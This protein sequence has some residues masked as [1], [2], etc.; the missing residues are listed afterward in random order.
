MVA[1]AAVQKFMTNLGKQQEIL[2]NVADMVIQTYVAEST[3]LRVEK[4]MDMKGE[5]AVKGQVAMMKCLIYDSCDIINKAGKDAI[6]SFAE[7]D[8]YRRY[9]DGIEAIH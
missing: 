8:E 1:G 6:N 4:L 5:E 7:G 2:M 9:D 3:L